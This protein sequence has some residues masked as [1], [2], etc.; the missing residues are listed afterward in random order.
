MIFWIRYN[1]LSQL[2]ID[3]PGWYIEHRIGFNS[4]YGCHLFWRMHICLAASILV[5]I[6]TNASKIAVN[7]G[8]SFKIISVDCDG[9]GGIWYGAGPAGFADTVDV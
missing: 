3:K 7:D 1:S 2:Q 5:I 4:E 8:S 6:C 9:C